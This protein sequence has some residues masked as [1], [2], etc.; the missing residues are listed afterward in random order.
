[1]NCHLTPEL[2]TSDRHMLDLSIGIMAYNEEEGI[3][4]LLDALLKQ[5]LVHANLKEIIV[6]A[7]GCTDRTEAVV[8][9]FIKQDPRIHLIVQTR[10]KG[11]ASAVNRFLAVASGH[12]CILESADT[13]PEPG[14]INRLTAP[15][16]LPEVGMTGGRPI[17]INSVNT[18]MGYAG[19][20]LWSLHHAVSLTNPKLGE[21]VA[22]RNVVREIPEDTAVDEAS[23]EAIL[24]KTGYKLC[25]VPEA[26]VRNKGPETVRDF[27]RQRR[28]IA[29]GHAY[30]FR[31]HGYRVSTSRLTG[32]LKMAIRYQSWCMKH[33]LWT[34]GTACLELTA[35]VLGTIDV[36]ARKHAPAIWDISLSTKSW[37]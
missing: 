30:L 34:L 7:S 2:E 22:F 25:Y 12:I 5:K 10:R 19:H 29:A 33:I 20:L 37:N 16:V 31:K 28:R 18:F 17:P 21:L 27:L 3:G 23:I 26:V 8:R 15:F 32:I 24:T 36:Y 4:R 1:M 13:V 9:D 11:K 35:R 14:A 6:V